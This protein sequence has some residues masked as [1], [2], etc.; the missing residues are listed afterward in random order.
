MKADFIVS[1]VDSIILVNKE[2]EHLSDIVLDLSKS[3]CSLEVQVMDTA[4]EPVSS[5]F[6]SL[7]IEMPKGSR[8]EYHRIFYTEE[9]NSEGLYWLDGLPSGKW[10]LRIG[11]TEYNSKALEVE[12]IPGKTARCKVTFDSVSDTYN[13][14]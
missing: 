4:N 13:Y 3:V 14:N 7:D 9:V 8:N 6:I 1:M 11:R 2:G 10:R 5:I 12:L